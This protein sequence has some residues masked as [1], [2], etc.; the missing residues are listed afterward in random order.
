MRGGTHD[1]VPTR[2]NAEKIF[3]NQATVEWYL[4]SKDDLAR[5]YQAQRIPFDWGKVKEVQEAALVL[6]RC[7]STSRGQALI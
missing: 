7:A 4:R 2:Q 3:P 5:S 1:A 6:A